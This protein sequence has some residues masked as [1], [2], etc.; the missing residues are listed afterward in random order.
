MIIDFQVSDIC[1][2]GGHGTVTMRQDGVPIDS[3]RVMIEDLR[4]DA[5]EV[6]VKPALWAVGLEMIRRADPATPAALKTKINE[7]TITVDY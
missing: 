3:K 5:A 6:K 1:A 2:A 4:Q 7:M